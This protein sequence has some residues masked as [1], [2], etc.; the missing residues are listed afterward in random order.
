MSVAVPRRGEGAYQVDVQVAETLGG[1]GDVAGGDAGW[2][3]TL[4]LWQL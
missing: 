4:P 1:V 2:D 3:V